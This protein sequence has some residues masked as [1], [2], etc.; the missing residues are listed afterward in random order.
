M[1]VALY[2]SY[3]SQVAKTPA[4]LEEAVN[5]LSWVHRMATVE[6]ITVHPQ[7]LTGTRRLLAHKTTK[8]RAHYSETTTISD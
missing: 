4:P 6:D 2:L 1:H 3:L 7:V 8:K 5:A